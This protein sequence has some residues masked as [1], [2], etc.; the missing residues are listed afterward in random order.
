[1]KYFVLILSFFCW[2]V[3]NVSGQTNK[4][5]R[6][7]KAQRSELQ[8]QITESEKMLRTMK[9]DVKSQLSDLAILNGQIN[10]QQKYVTAI[11][12]DIKALDKEIALVETE[13]DTLEANL[14][15]MKEKY[16][17]SVQYAYKENHT[18]QDKLMF[19]FSAETVSQMFRRMRYVREYTTYLRVQGEQVKE[20]QKTVQQKKADLL[21]AKGEKSSLLRQSEQERKKLEVKKDEQKQLLFSLQKK[22]KDV[23]KEIS[24]KQ[25]QSQ[26]LNEQIDRLVEQEIAA[27]KKRE[28][29]RRKKEMA[30]LEAERRKKAELAKNSEKE[31]AT[32]KESENIGKSS[33]KSVASGNNSNTSK[34]KAERM[35]AYKVD[36]EDRLVSGGFER[37]K[38]LMPVPITGPYMIVGHYGVYTVAGLK[39]VKLDN[40][41]IDIKGQ[42]GASARSIFQGE[43]SSVFSYGGMRGVL[44]RHGSYISVYCNLS[45][46]NVRAGQKVKARDAIGKVAR[47]EDGDYVLQFQLRRETRK[48]NPEQW[49]S[50]R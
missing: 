3:L 29:E 13:L 46:V 16:L 23:Q 35:G 36:D 41:G 19:I 49:L 42:S 8:K 14:N 12:E 20:Q 48:L 45:S 37:N 5:I 38:G 4:K 15:S 47:N 28:E 10:N 2:L 24:Q 26:R 39:G 21:A 50:R 7:L 1:M 31:V 25:K 17:K 11:E 18:I 9:K 33:S 6:N 22:Q 40:K 27:A 30:R 34:A 32:G 44:I 43:V